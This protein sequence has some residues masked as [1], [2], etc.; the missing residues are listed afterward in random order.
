MPAP[1]R[2]LKPGYVA[3]NVTE[4][5]RSSRFFESI[6]G[7]TEEPGADG[8]RF[9]RCSADHHNLALYPSDAPG[10]KRVGFQLESAP[11]LERA[12]EW[13]EAQGWPTQ[14][15]DADERRVLRQGP[16][17]RFRVPE[18]SLCFEF[19]AEIEQASTP[20]VPTLAK[21]QRLGHI[22]IGSPQPEAL[23]ATLTEKLNFRVSD[24]FGDQVTF[25][26]CFPNPYHHSFG[27]ARTERD[28]LHHVNFMVS[29]IDD[30]GR[31]LNR[32][33]K[34]EVEIVYGPGRHDISNSIFL[35]YLDPDGMTIEYSFGMEEFAEVG[36]REAR[37]L[38]MRPEILDCWG[39][40]PA[41]K[42]A[43]VGAIERAAGS[44]V[45]TRA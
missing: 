33:R 30:V 8:V 35:Y 26:R 37:V 10:L 40:L 12:R 23:L 14:A 15:V 24:Y 29:E 28:C 22:V 21:I 34:N 17:F 18:S 45:E 19:Y 44:S 1:F 42:F 7:L 31:A 20:F 4:P 36:A 25:L 13:I 3:L 32:L 27:V 43:K 6:V 5:E 9:F 11:D 2:Y 39:G 41:P 16:S 38:P